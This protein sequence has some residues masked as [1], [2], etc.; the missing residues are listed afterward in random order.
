MLEYNK[1][2][3][4]RIHLT[5][6]VLFKLDR[7]VSAN[8][9]RLDTFLSED[10]FKGLGVSK[11]KLTY[12]QPLNYVGVEYGFESNPGISIC[13]FK[14]TERLND[15]NMRIKSITFNPSGDYIIPVTVTVKNAS[16]QTTSL[17]QHD[18][19]SA[20]ESERSIP[21]RLGFWIENGTV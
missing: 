14:L 11:K 19:M 21:Y 3:A 8:V 13:M 20:C 1:K 5:D 10:V 17:S 15:L 12:N 2:A 6:D 7:G 16:S 9:V 4:I 18:I